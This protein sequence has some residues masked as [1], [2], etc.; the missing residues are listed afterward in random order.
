MVESVLE[1]VRGHVAESSKHI[2]HAREVLDDKCEELKD[3]SKRAFRNMRHAAED[4]AEDTGHLV[5]KRP[6]PAVTGAVVAGLA[7]GLLLGWML[8]RRD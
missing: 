6:L 3:Q 1:E 2:E 5:K 4:L 7:V 8:A